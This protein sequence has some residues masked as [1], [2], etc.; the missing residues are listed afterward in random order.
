MTTLVRSSFCN[1]HEC[2]PKE[3]NVSCKM[4]LGIRK[5]VIC[6]MKTPVCRTSH[7]SIGE[8]QPINFDIVFGDLDFHTST[9]DPVARL[10]HSAQAFSTP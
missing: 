9:C 1:Q 4:L 10:L 6:R 5:L 3:I 7:E 2:A 8:S